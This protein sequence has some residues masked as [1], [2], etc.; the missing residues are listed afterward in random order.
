MSLYKYKAFID[1]LIAEL[2]SSGL[3]C[4]IYK[5]PGSPVGY[6]DDLAACSLDKQS[7]EGAAYCL[8]TKS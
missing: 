2:E 8:Q 3:C 5:L 1:S 4:K 6:A 7:V